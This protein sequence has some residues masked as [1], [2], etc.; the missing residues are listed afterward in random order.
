MK[1]LYRVVLIV[2]GFMGL[3][4]AAHADSVLIGTDPSTAFG[5]VG[6]C[7][8]FSDCQA[9]VQSFTLSSQVTITDIRVVMSHNSSPTISDDGHFFVGLFDAP[10]S[11]TLSV[12]PNVGSG[13][14]PYGPINNDP[15]K[16]TIVYG[17]FDFSGLDITLGPG[18]YYLEFAGAGVGPARATASVTT[19]VATFGKTLYC[20]PTVNPQ[21]CNNPSRWQPFSSYYDAD[22]F[23]VTIIGSVV[24][25]EPA[26]WL[27]LATGIF[28]ATGVARRSFNWRR[29]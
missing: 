9:D 15:S 20:D 5:S 27:L 12:A 25:P 16:T 11:A 22:P 14:L 19:S 2:V 29:S 8:S 18:T 28:G 10:I 24:A 7:P 3:S 4:N 13:D 23:A 1:A 17:L 6:L 26:S 21:D